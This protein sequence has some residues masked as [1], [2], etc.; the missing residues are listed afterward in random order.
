MARAGLGLLC[1][2]YVGA[3]RRQRETY[4]FNGIALAS[5]LLRRHGVR[6]DVRRS[7]TEYGKQKEKVH[8]I[9]YEVLNTEDWWN[10]GIGES[11]G[12]TFQGE[13]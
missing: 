8:I 11:C 7:Q 6:S 5:V 13:V 3:F 12:G 4:Q 10:W 1:N 2:W 9:V